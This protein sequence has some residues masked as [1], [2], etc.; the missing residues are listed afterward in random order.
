[1]DEIPR[2]IAGL[3][4]DISPARL[5][6]SA[7]GSLSSGRGA[8]RQRGERPKMKSLKEQTIRRIE[9]SN[10]GLAPVLRSLRSDRKVPLKVIAHDLSVS[11]STVSS[12]ENGVRIPTLRMLMRLSQY[13]EVPVC[14][15][16]TGKR[17]AGR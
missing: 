3:T 12:W 5:L 4:G 7:I 13:F 17:C 9:R 10:S 14:K 8:S 1:M 15:L 11:V 2:G 16:V 6:Q